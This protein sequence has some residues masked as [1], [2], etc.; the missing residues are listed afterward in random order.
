MVHH[1]LAFSETAP[2]IPGSLQFAGAG[3]KAINFLTE[4]NKVLTLHLF[5]EGV[6]PSGWSISGPVF[7]HIS[8]LAPKASK[9]R[10]QN[11]GI[12]IDKLH[13]A[14]GKN[15]LWLKATNKTELT[16]ELLSQFLCLQQT[17]TG[18]YGPLGDLVQSGDISACFPVLKP[19][20][21]WFEGGEPDWQGIIGAGPGLTPSHDDMLVGML[22]CAY[23]I[24][25]F[26]DKAPALLPAS[27]DLDYWTT[28]VSAGYLSQ[29]RNGFFSDSLLAVIDSSPD[30]FYDNAGHFLSHGHYSGADTLLGMWLFLSLYHHLFK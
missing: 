20:K 1:A 4:D 14:K 29:A 24:P 26:R 9:I 22:A 19:L 6:S 10:L 5:G 23:S 25:E 13:L 15:G 11:S 18:L 3:S 27:L 17:Q 21:C 2:S 16:F 12:C 30:T 8:Q 28:S 7:R